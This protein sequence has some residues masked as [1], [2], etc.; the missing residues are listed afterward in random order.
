MDFFGIRGRFALGVVKCTQSVAP[1]SAREQICM[2]AVITEGDREH[3]P[4][5]Q[6]GA[7]ELRQVCCCA[8]VLGEWGEER[9]TC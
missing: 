7:G 9:A 4:A 6:G 3:T 1:C 5:E 8:N 2:Y